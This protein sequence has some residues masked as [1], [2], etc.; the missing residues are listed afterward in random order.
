MSPDLLVHSLMHELRAIQR[1]AWKLAAAAIDDTVRRP[2]EAGFSDGMA[3]AQQIILLR[4]KVD[5]LIDM[6]E[7]EALDYIKREILDR[8]REHGEQGMH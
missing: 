7:P 1:D 8:D 6:L 5:L 2:I 3:L 4:Q